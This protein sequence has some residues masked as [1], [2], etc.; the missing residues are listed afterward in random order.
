LNETYGA[1]PEPTTSLSAVTSAVDFRS[2]IPGDVR[3]RLRPPADA[4]PDDA[5]RVVREVL[6]AV[7]EEGDAAV[8][9]Y[10]ERFDGVAIAPDHFKVAPSE[11]EAAVEGADPALLDALRA[12]AARIEAYHRHQAGPGAEV[13][14]DD[15]IRV[16]ELRRP[17]DRVGLYAPGGLHSYPSSVLMMAIPARVAGVP[18]VALCIPPRK[19]GTVAPASL[20]AAALTGVSEVW[21]LGGAQA[22]AAMAYGTQTVPAVD[23]IVGPGNVYVALAKQEVAGLVG[24]ESLAGPSEVAI[25][26]D[27]GAPAEWIALDLY[28][29]AEHGPLGSC[30]L[31]TWE[32][33]VA[34]EVEGRLAALIAL[35][36]RRWIR[37]AGGHA[38]R[39]VL[40][41]GPEAAIDVANAYAPEHLQLMVADPEPLLKRVRHA[42]AVFCGYDAP[43]ALGDYVAG[44]NHVLPTAGTARFASALR[45]SAFEK[46]THAVFVKDYEPLAATAATIAAAEGLTAHARSL[47]ERAR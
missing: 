22:I 1:A 47:T 10:T 14:E 30:L 9:R 36:D 44:P 39:T 16:V 19:D 33:A 2:G 18:E 4:R 46:V 41:D 3:R 23:L 42:G 27:G 45:V 25:V 7:R 32:E 38:F 15:A 13:V 8:A 6:D 12:A 31:V 37:E 5:L 40:V 21:R 35:D 24:I 29:Q 43:T 20:A 17:V 34:A 11:I 28:A 26:A